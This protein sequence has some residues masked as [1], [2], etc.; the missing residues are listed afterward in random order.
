MFLRRNTVLNASFVCFCLVEAIV[1]AR[2]VTAQDS[3]MAQVALLKAKRFN[4]EGMYDSSFAHAERALALFR[5]AEISKGVGESLIELGLADQYRKRFKSALA[6]YLEGAEILEVEM[7][8]AELATSGLYN[9]LGGV[10]TDLGY[11]F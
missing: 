2:V 5:S 4:T 7:T 11:R 1:G 9:K 3:S 6:Y 10:S 8:D